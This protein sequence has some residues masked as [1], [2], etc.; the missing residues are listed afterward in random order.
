MAEV[1]V[2]QDLLE[3]VLELGVVLRAGAAGA[4]GPRRED[5]PGHEG[6]R[7]TG[8]QLAKRLEGKL[9]AVKVQ[10]PQIEA[11]FT[12]D[13]RLIKYLVWLLGLI[14]IMP[15]ARW[16]DLALMI[17]KAL[18]DELGSAVERMEEVTRHIRADIEARELGL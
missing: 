16:A 2:E 12:Q 18:S 6:D 15:H 11:S 9:V 8:V 1:L 4:V 5:R 7:L 10:R 14:R 13:M 3:V 17:R